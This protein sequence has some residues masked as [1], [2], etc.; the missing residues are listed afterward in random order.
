MC[1]MK[2]DGGTRCNVA[3]IVAWSRTGALSLSCRSFR[4]KVRI[5]LLSVRMTS[6]EVI[7][8][9]WSTL[10]CTALFSDMNGNSAFGNRFTR[11]PASHLYLV[12]A[13]IVVVVVKVLLRR[14]SSRATSAMSQR[15]THSE[16][17]L[18][19]ANSV[20]EGSVRR[21]QAMQTKQIRSKML[22]CANAVEQKWLLQGKLNTNK[23]NTN[24][25]NRSSEEKTNK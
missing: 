4:I 22:R 12:T 25:V 20:T 13:S 1:T 5:V 17:S 6:G 24:K 14:C 10:C 2:M 8:P 23:L 7:E 16:R 18:T 19:S 3:F 21:R 11:I 9:I 15:V